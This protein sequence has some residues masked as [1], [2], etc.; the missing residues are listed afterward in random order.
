MGNRDEILND[1]NI[2]DDQTTLVIDVGLLNSAWVEYNKDGEIVSNKVVPTNDTYDNAFNFN[3]VVLEGKILEYVNRHS[4]IGHIQLV[5][6]SND[7]VLKYKELPTLEEISNDVK[8]NVIEGL[9]VILNSIHYYKSEFIVTVSIVQEYFDIL[10]N[11]LYINMFIGRDKSVSA[12]TKINV[13][14]KVASSLEDNVV[15]I[16]FGA[17]GTKLIRVG[18]GITTDYKLIPEL[19]FVDNLIKINDGHE[20]VDF[21]RAIDYDII[22]KIQEKGLTEFEK[23]IMAIRDFVK[24]S[25]VYAVGQL[26]NGN[27]VDRILPKVSLLR[28]SQHIEDQLVS[29]KLVLATPVKKNIY[30]DESMNKY[31]LYASMDESSLTKVDRYIYKEDEIRDYEKTFHNRENRE[32]LVARKMEMIRN[33]EGGQTNENE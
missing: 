1:G 31:S 6:P 8:D 24:S 17:S 18:K 19:G 28:N 20:Q 30:T 32:D 9:S 21:M 26:S 33:R 2:S 23:E 22:D 29:E 14:N 4:N 3:Y 7:I 12:C 15:L 10:Y 27:W 5:L 11:N 25:K 16:D 13:M